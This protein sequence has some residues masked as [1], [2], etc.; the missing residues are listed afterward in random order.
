MRKERIHDQIRSVFRGRC[1]K[2]VGQ[3]SNGLLM[4]ATPRSVPWG[5]LGGLPL[6]DLT[7]FSIKQV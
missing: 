4:K 3:L 1:E 2:A 5:A 6:A 7:K